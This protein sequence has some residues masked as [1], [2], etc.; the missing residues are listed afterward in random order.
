MTLNLEHIVAALMFVGVRVSG[1]V[2]FAPFLG[3]ASVPVRV[4]VGI[5]LALTALLYPALATQM[6]PHLD[7]LNWPRVLAGEMTIGIILGIALNLVFDGAQLAGQILGVQMGFS[8]VNIIDPQTQVDTP[9]LSLFHQMI[10]LLIFLQLDVHHWI[11]RGVARSFEY[12]PA[13]TALVTP[14]VTEHLT[15]AAGAVWLIGLQIAAPALI[16]TMLADVAL[17]FLGKASPQLPVL[18]LG[19]SIKSVLGMLVMIGTLALWPSVF[20]RY[21]S[22]AVNQGERILHLAR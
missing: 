16:A 2:L 18:F 5:V 4:K 20:E 8:L 13:G 6:P 9:V 3:S 11:I 1:L 22:A 7:A 12:L 10:T 17:G 14:A 19:L 21:F 15:R